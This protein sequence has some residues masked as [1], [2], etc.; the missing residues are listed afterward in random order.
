M[1]ADQSDSFQLRVFLLPHK[2]RSLLRFT[3]KQSTAVYTKPLPT[4]ARSKRERKHLFPWRKALGVSLVEA[5]TVEVYPVKIKQLLVQ[6]RVRVHTHTHTLARKLISSAAAAAA[7]WNFLQVIVIFC[8]L[9]SKAASGRRFRKCQPISIF[10][11]ES[12]SFRLEL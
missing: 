1:P 12:K 3:E 6:Q 10:Y 2:A 11:R 4:P 5:F 9:L 7:G 8:G